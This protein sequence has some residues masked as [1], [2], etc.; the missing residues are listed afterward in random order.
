MK[1]FGFEIRKETE[2]DLSIPSFAPRE[3]DDGA[4]VVSAGGTLV[5]I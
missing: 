2:E 1:L 5:R 3:T 4:L